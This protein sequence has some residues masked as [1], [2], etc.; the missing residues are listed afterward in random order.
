MVER[1]STSS[2]ALGWLDRNGVQP[3]TL[4][5][6]AEFLIVE[7]LRPESTICLRVAQ[8]LAVLIGENTDDAAALGAWM[9]SKR[10][11]SRT[12]NGTR[13]NC[14]AFLRGAGLS[15]RHIESVIAQ[16]SLVADSDSLKVRLSA[17]TN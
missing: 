11:I 5:S 1:S 7:T 3:R 2:F 6:G 17:M 15:D 4:T 10:S 13:R 8:S 14:E 12:I 16:H 9:V